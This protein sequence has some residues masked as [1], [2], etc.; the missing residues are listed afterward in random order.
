MTDLKFIEAAVDAQAE[1]ILDANDRIWEYAEPP[2]KEMQSSALLGRLL[3]E[4][5]FTV[6]TGLAGIP[7]CFT[8]T[9]VYGTGKPVMGILGEYDAL[10]GLS[11]E[12]AL[13]VKK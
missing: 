11:Q 2:F 9:F 3:K 8:G 6:E 4:A 10:P 12:A 13:P 1:R 7:T 5:G